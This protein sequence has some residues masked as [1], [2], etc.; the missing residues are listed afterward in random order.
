M[1][2]LDLLTGLFVRIVAFLVLVRCVL[3]P[4][5]Q[6][7]G[8]CRDPPRKQAH[9]IGDERRGTT[10]PAST[11]VEAATMR[12][13]LAL[14]M[15]LGCRSESLPPCRWSWASLMSTPF[16]WRSIGC[17]PKPRCTVQLHKMRFC[18]VGKVFRNDSSW[19]SGVSQVGVRVGRTR[20]Y[21]YE[22]AWRV[23]KTYLGE[24]DMI[25]Y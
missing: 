11:R 4:W 5:L 3:T 17:T 16:S 23:T 13:M 15:V 1:R 2:L 8:P 7:Q 19:Q 10:S 6:V 20:I 25:I 24:N 18:E 22:S 21:K 14:C 12:A 9:P